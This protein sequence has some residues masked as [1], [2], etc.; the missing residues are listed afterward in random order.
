MVIRMNEPLPCPICGGA[1]DAWV[2][3]EGDHCWFIWCPVCDLGFGLTQEGDA[4]YKT[5]E[6]CIAMWNRRH[7][8]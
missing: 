5:Q 2:M 4:V 8:P 6:D 7:P 3:D 1:V